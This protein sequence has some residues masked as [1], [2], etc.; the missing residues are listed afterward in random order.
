MTNRYVTGVQAPI[1]HFASGFQLINA[2]GVPNDPTEPSQN[3]GVTYQGYVAPGGKVTIFES[4]ASLVTID[5]DTS[6]QKP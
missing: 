3:V 1:S 2:W 6:P 4:L 5:H